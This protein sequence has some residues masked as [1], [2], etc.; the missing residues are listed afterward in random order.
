[1][2]T[3][4]RPGRRANGEGLIRPRSDGRWEGRS[5]LPNGKPTSV[6]GKSQKEVQQKLQALRQTWCV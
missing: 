3:A 6:Y 5:L 4:T 2:V 1:M